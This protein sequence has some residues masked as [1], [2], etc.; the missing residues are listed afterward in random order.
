MPI[1]MLSVIPQD[2]LK[3]LL[4]LGI[5]IL[6]QCEFVKKGSQLDHSTSLCLYYILLGLTPNTSQV[7]I[8]DQGW[9]FFTKAITCSQPVLILQQEPT[10]PQ[11]VIIDQVSTHSH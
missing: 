8:L 3:K 11:A 5:S 9:T 2:M 1:T 7:L 4:P 10:S 6:K